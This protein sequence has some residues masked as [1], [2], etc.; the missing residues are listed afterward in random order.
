MQLPEVTH[1]WC[2]MD[3]IGNYLSW[4]QLTTVGLAIWK[5]NIAGR[6][7]QIATLKDMD[8]SLG[9]FRKM[10]FI[11]RRCLLWN[12][13]R[14]DLIWLKFQYVYIYILFNLVVVLV[15]PVA[16]TWRSETERMPIRAQ[17]RQWRREKRWSC[18]WCCHPKKQRTKTAVHTKK[19]VE[20]HQLP[21]GNDYPK[22]I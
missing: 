3:F 22:H 13:D 4:N 5:I 9:C 12:D 6:I 1:L 19:T 7:F 21:M 10:S 2:L 14:I 20:W 17:Q 18:L 16:P 11:H 15:H 8:E